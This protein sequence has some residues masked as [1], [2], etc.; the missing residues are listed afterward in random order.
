MSEHAELEVKLGDQVVGWLR[1]SPVGSDVTTF[2]FSHSY[3][4]LS[5]RPVLGQCFVD[6]PNKVWTAK[7]RLPAFF[8]NLLPDLDSP[9]RK[10][11]CAQFHVPAEREFILLEQLGEDLPGNIVVRL[12]A[13]DLDE[14]SAE[15]EIPADMA[16]DQ[17]LS[18]PLPLPPEALRF[19]LAGM[20]LKLS[21]RREGRGMTVPAYGRGGD[22]I[23]KFPDQVYPRVPENEW[24]MMRWAQQS[25]IA[26]P[27]FELIEFRHLSNV[28]PGFADDADSQCYA[29]RRFDRP[30]PGKRIH[31][32]DFAQV[33]AVYDRGKYTRSNFETVGSII[34]ALGGEID[35]RE[36]VRRLVFMVL[37]GNADAHLK[38]WSLIYLD[39]VHASLS[40]AYDFVSTVLYPKLARKLAMNFNRSTSFD[41]VSLDGFRRFA[42]RLDRDP[43]EMVRWVRDD[44]MRSLDAWSTLHVELPLDTGSKTLL[45]EH[46]SRLQ[47]FARGK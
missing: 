11:V 43:E 14:P 31:M 34:H 5:P 9:L 3:L 21:M 27:E 33:L 37:S 12:S 18:S 20:Q 1:R 36:Y 4:A 30:G 45:V 25:G 15:F 39:G 44:V 2:R 29:V 40:P 26:V 17:D 22:W 38:N 42:R 28:P 16:A 46:Q 23:V 13:S 41:E 19:S 8:S 10:A 24:A 35:L 47:L 32:E 7:L 6:D